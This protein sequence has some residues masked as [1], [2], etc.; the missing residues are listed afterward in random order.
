MRELRR[1]HQE[2]QQFNPDQ[3]PE[4]IENEEFTGKSVGEGEGAWDL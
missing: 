4:L 2:N 1:H 3:T